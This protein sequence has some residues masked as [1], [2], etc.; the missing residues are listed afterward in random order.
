MMMM[1]MMSR[2]VGKNVVARVLK[3]CVFFSGV[4]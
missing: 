1:M 3:R 4:R 2:V